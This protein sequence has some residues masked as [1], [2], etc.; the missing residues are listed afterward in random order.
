[1]KEIT[2]NYEK[3]GRDGSGCVVY[4]QDPVEI[5]A[6]GKLSP[7]VI[8]LPV[9]IILNQNFFA[10]ESKE[11]EKAC[12]F[13]KPDLDQTLVFSCAV[14]FDRIGPPKWLLCQS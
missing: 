5:D 1:M 8:T 10:M 14:G 13:E 3:N 12:G 9:S 7:S 6:T 11:F 4:V 2:E